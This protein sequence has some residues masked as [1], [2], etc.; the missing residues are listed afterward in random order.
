MNILIISASFYPKN[1][2]RSFRT[3]ELAKE[4]CEQGHIVDVAVPRIDDVHDEFERQHKG[5]RILQLGSPN[6]RGLK[7]KG[8]LGSV[9]SRVVNR[10]FYTFFDL[11]EIEFYFLSRNIVKSV[12]K[13]YDL[14]ITVAVPHSIHWGVASVWKK[15]SVA[16]KWIADCGDPFVYNFNDSFR[17]P[18]YF[19]YFEN[20]F[21]MKCDFVTLPFEDLK[22]FFNQ[23]YS[24]KFRIIPQG[25]NFRGIELDNYKEKE[26]RR[27]AYSGNIIPGKRDFFSLLDDLS[28]N[29]DN[30]EFYI[31]TKQRAQYEEYTLNRNVIIK[32]YLDRAELLYFL[33]GVDFLINVDTQSKGGVSNAIPS[34]LIDYTFTKRPILSFIHGKYDPSLL[35]EFMSG[36]YSRRR[37]D[38]N[39]E[40]YRIERIV[41]SIIDLS[42]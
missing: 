14:L 28:D 39:I 34:K 42:T 23:K 40:N 2:P 20:D 35:R 12:N 13:E 38:V 4:F 21:L 36:N 22:N 11:P 27:F 17:R 32:D 5:V 33:S 9:V 15:Y 10:V 31:F 24:D 41:T 3:T 1:S 16:K 6:W 37:D 29:Y 18:F 25:F 30:Y 7:L 19:K 26:F 8:R